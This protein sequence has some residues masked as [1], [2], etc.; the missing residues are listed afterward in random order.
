MLAGVLRRRCHEGPLANGADWYNDDQRLKA[1]LTEMLEIKRGL[2]PGG[3]A[4]QRTEPDRRKHGVFPNRQAVEQCCMLKQKT[5]TPVQKRALTMRQTSQ[6]LI[7]Q[8]NAA[9]VRRNETHDT[10]HRDGF[11]AARSPQ[12]HQ[13]FALGDRQVDTTQHVVAAEAFG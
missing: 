5:E 3:A 7:I 10:F 13:R 4:R 6:F 1:A 12:N 2:C 9:L 8:P 11:A